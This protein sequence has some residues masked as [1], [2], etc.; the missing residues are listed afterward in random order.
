MGLSDA[1]EQDPRP[2]ASTLLI[3]ILTELLPVADAKGATIPSLQWFLGGKPKLLASGSAETRSAQTVDTAYPQLRRGFH[4]LTTNP[5]LRDA[6]F[7][8]VPRF[9]FVLTQDSLL[10]NFIGVGTLRPCTML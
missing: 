2:K 8:W 3:Q 4:R 9:S 10:I 7:L 5:P 1:V 6:N